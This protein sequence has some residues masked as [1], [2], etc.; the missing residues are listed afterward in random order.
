MQNNPR[1][2]LSFALEVKTFIESG[3]VEQVFQHPAHPYTRALLDAM[4]IPDPVV[5]RKRDRILLVGDVP[6][7]VNAVVG[8]KFVSRC[9]IYLQAGPAEQQLCQSQRPELSQLAAG[10][11][12]ACHFPDPAPEVGSN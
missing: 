1:S 11:R 3:P 4:P 7:P 5:E 8:C 10:Q 2:F 12:L 9:P 6:S